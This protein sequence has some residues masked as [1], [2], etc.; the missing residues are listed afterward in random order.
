[1]KE[2]VG[3]RIRSRLL[4]DRSQTMKKAGRG[5]ALSPGME[6]RFT[7]CLPGERWGEPSDET[8]PRGS[9]MKSEAWKRFR[10]DGE[11]LSEGPCERPGEIFRHWT[12]L[13]SDF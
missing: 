10:H 8:S 6:E 9:Q 3:G 1:M 4:L 7:S 13:S 11:H 5:L 12:V 2:D